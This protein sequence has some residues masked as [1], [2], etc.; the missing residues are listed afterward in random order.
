MFPEQANSRAKCEDIF[1]AFWRFYE[2]AAAT[3]IRRV[4]NFILSSHH[5]TVLLAHSNIPAFLS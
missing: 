4:H 5:T 1:L 3:A 2:I